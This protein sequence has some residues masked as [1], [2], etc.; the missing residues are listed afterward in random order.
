MD[1]SR[2]SRTDVPSRILKLALVGSVLTVA[3]VQYV[4]TT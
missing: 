2:G 1:W 3:V 4:Y